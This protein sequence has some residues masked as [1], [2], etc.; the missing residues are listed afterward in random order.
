MPDMDGFKF[1]EDFGLEMDLLII[2]V[3]HGGCDYFIKPVRIEALRN[4]WQHVV[5]KRKDVW[6]DFE[7]SDIIED[8]E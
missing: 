7:Q 5:W 2:S 1:L 8:G 4:I 6:K 3:T